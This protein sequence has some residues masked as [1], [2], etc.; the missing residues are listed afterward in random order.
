MRITFVIP[1]LG[2]TGGIKVVFQ[3]ANELV[4]RGHTVNLLACVCTRKYTGPRWTVQCGLIKG[5]E[6]VRRRI[7]GM[8]KES[9]YPLDPR[10]NIIVAPRPDARYAPDADVVIATANRTA[11]F[12]VE[13]PKSKGDKFYLIQHYEDW[14]RDVSLVD[15]TWKM[16]LKK[17]VIASWLADL[18]RDRF[19]EEVVAV[20]PNGIDHSQFYNDN[21]TFNKNKRI[22]MVY[23]TMEF[24][25]VND[26]IEAVKAVID[27][28]PEVQLVMFGTKNP[29]NYGIPIEFHLDPPQD[30]IRDIYNSCDIFICP[31]ISEGFG[32]PSMEAMACKCAVVATDV[33]C[34]PDVAVAGK[35]ALVVPPSHPE[36]ITEAV[37]DLV[38]NE[39][40]LR[41]IALAGYDRVRQYTWQNATE[42]M[43]AV[44]I[45]EC[46]RE[47][48]GAD[49]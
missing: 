22:L 40:K 7:L 39:D 34:I 29:P 38:E 16:P 11:D 33:G 26:G 48:V 47:R 24:K 18:A 8:K 3:Y 46:N 23:Y 25:G 31:S 4:R 49:A 27:R 13:Y 42:Q 19:G 30:K 20:I 28:H 37:I 35:T 41:E 2:L 9:W 5:R 6:F 1:N 44:L 45:R 12:V 43:E 36:M 10:I 32:L 15:R 14:D 21:R 17:I